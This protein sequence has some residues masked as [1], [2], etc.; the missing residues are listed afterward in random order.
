MNKWIFFLIV[1]VLVMLSVSIVSAEGNL[2][3]ICH[4]NKNERHITAR[5]LKAH[6]EHGD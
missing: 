4:E 3:E 6:L 1:L 5:A 2:I